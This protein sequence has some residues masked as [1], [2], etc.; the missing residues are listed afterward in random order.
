MLQAADGGAEILVKTLCESVHDIK[1]LPAAVGC[2]DSMVTP[3]PCPF[4]A[5]GLFVCPSV[6]MSA[7]LS[8]CLSDCLSVCL[9]LFLCDLASLAAR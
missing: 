6:C 7:C 4:Q 9:S 1:I 8:V 3:N 5:P 2:N